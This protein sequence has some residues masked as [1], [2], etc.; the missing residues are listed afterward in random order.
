MSINRDERRKA[1]ISKETADKLNQLN[2]PCTVIE[3]VQLA[4]GV[5][6]DA[7]DQYHKSLNPLIVSMSLQIELL[8]EI[9]ISKEVLNEEEYNNALEKKIQQFNEDKEKAMEEL[10]KQEEQAMAEAENESPK[11]DMKPQ[12]LEIVK[13]N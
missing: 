7:V 8:K 9:L 11:T 13:D 10:R 4:Q 6:K 3:A 12:P 2:S 5:A 1:G